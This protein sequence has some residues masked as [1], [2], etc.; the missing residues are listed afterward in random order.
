MNITIKAFSYAVLLLGAVVSHAQT[1]LTPTTLA[2]ALTDSKTKITSVTSAT[3]FV[4]GT[5]VAYVDRELMGVQAVNG[6]SITFIR[7]MA[8]T[9]AGPHTVTASVFVW[10]PS[11]VGPFFVGIPQGSCTRSKELYLPRIDVKSGTI[12]DCLGGFWAAGD[13]TGTAAVSKFRTASPD[14]GVFTY[15][16]QLSNTATIATELYCTEVWLPTN[17]LVTG[18]GVLKGTTATTD[19]WLVVLYDSSGVALA[20]SA[21]AGTLVATANVY[22]QFPLTSQYFAVGPSQY[23]ACMQSNG[24]TATFQALITGADANLLTKGQ[25][26][27]VFGT[28]SA[29][30]V[31]TTFTTAVG[32][33]VYLY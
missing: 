12:S 29:L 21:L 6:T 7:G 10:N 23:F 24:T 14:L 22:Q 19:K 8:G 20:N 4:A 26:G 33:A 32:P 28:V 11:N 3:G 30:T 16:T 13:V 18:I 25:T 15:T 27:V 2:A 17:K 5:T 31:P 9:F 1:I